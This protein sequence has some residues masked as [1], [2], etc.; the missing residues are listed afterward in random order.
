MDVNRWKQ[1]YE[2]LQPSKELRGR[3]RTIIAKRKRS[4]RAKLTAS[5]AAALFAVCVIT[6]NL[7]PQAAKAMCGTEVGKN[8]VRVLTFGRYDFSDHGYEAKI[9]TPQITGLSDKEL[10]ERLNQELKDNANAIIEQ[11]QQDVKQLQAEFGEETVHMGID[12]GYVVRT[13]T[14]QYLSIDIYLVNTVG[15]SSTVHTFYTVAKETGTLVTLEGMFQGD[16]ITPI[17]RYIKEEIQRRNE[18]E[19]GM[20]VPEQFEAIKPDQNFYLNEDGQLVI[21]FD[22]YEIAA[23]AQGSPEFIIPQEILRPILK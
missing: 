19:G 6:L 9:V 4:W 22:K 12:Y 23:G 18:E 14:D 7:S 16:Y 2:A 8:I 3:I 5:A 13:D 17:S 10:E 21:C 20:Y 1:E 11:Y 15:S